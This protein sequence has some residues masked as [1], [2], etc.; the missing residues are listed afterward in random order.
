MALQGRWT[1]SWPLAS[2]ELARERFDR[3]VTTESRSHW[4]Y[5]RGYRRHRYRPWRQVATM[6]FDFPGD[7]EITVTTTFAAAVGATRPTTTSFIVSAQPEPAQR[8]YSFK[9]ISGLKLDGIQVGEDN[10]CVDGFNLQFDNA[11]QTQR[12]IGNGSSF[13]GNVSFPTTFTPSGS[14]TISWSKMAYQ[15]WK[16]Q[17]TGDASV[18]SSP[19]ATP[20]AAIASAYRRWR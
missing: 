19:S 18:W 3:W 17:Q 16:A 13:P 9:D 11:V 12:C 8:R 1:S 7:N 4:P 10:A 5:A 15:L 6:A 2:A 14:I 20:T